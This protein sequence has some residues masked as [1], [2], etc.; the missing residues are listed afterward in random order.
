MGQFENYYEYVA[1]EARDFVDEYFDEAL[2]GIRDGDTDLYTFI[3]DYRLHEWCDNNFIY[4]DLSEA[5]EIIEQSNKV[6]EDSGLWEG[7]Q[8]EEAL[9]TKAFFTYR[10]DMEYE[11]KDIFKSMLNEEINS[12]EQKLEELEEKLEELQEEHG[13]LDGSEECEERVEELEQEIEDMEEKIE[14][15]EQFIGYL[16]DAIKGM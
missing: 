9:K 13:E 15:V 8:P 2:D 4:V 14:E 11:V 3:N 1:N 16:E 7:Q 10:N 6:E 12:Q 5:V